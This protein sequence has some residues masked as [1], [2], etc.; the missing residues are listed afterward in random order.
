M[1]FAKHRACAI[2]AGAVMLSRCN[3]RARVAAPIT[4]CAPPSGVMSFFFFAAKCWS[5]AHQT[6]RACDACACGRCAGVAVA[7]ASLHRLHLLTLHICS[8]FRQ[9]V[10]LGSSAKRRL[11]FFAA[12]SA[13]RFASYPNLQP[14]SPPSSTRS[15]STRPAPTCRR[16]VVV[17]RTCC[18]LLP[19]C[20]LGLRRRSFLFR[21]LVRAARS[22]ALAQQ[23]QLRRAVGA[24]FFLLSGCRHA[25]LLS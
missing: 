15:R 4:A 22:A 10:P 16:C 19:S 14:C 1:R 2:R 23:G 24:L 21:L 11:P 25:V 8:P 17:A 6:P 12:F 5:F 9:S 18:L 7:Q 13:S 3:R 20:L